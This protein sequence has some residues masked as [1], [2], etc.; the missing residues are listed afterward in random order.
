[1]CFFDHIKSQ[2]LTLNIEETDL[3]SVFDYESQ[4]YGYIDRNGK[5]VISP[6]FEKAS[7]FSEGLAVVDKDGRRGII[8]Y[9]GKFIYLQAKKQ[10]APFLTMGHFSEGLILA[11]DKPLPYASKHGYIDPCGHWIVNPQ[12]QI[13]SD[14]QN[15][16]TLVGINKKY[17]FIDK[18][19]NW[20]IPPKYNDAHMFS[21]ELACVKTGGKY[22]YINLDDNIVIPFQYDNAKPFQ[23]GFAAA[24]LE[25]KWGVI[26][27]LGNWVIRPKYQDVVISYDETILFTCISVKE[28]MKYGM[29]DFNENWI[30]QPDY[31]LPIQFSE[32]LAAV[33]GAIDDFGSGAGFMDQDGNW[34]IEPRFVTA[35]PF[36]NGLAEVTWNEF[37]M[38]GPWVDFVGYI[39]KNGNMV[40]QTH[41]EGYTP[42]VLP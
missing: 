30:I 6:S 34:V 40:Y 42:R 28:N 24:C 19:G 22:G 9:E 35:Y 14:F 13:A 2:L 8:N 4:L 12:F 10:N 41:P 7:N 29:I 26:D 3:L 32:G 11:T 39:N 31:A 5:W 1:M 23:N 37:D 20:I 15:G 33:S 18:S 17:G 21:Y 38:G 25:N 16:I 36:K 27:E